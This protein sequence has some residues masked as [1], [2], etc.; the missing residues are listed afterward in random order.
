MTAE[1]AGLDA[2]MPETRE[3]KEDTNSCDRESISAEKAASGG[4]G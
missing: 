3:K 1:I 2:R 4:D